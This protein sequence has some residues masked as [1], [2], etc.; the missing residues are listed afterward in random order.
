MMKKIVI[1]MLVLVVWTTSLF[2][3]ITRGQADTVILQHLQNIGL[4][5]SLLYVNVN[6]PS[7]S[8]IVITTSNAEVFSV[9]YACWAY[10]LKISEL[11]QCRYFFVKEDNGKLL[12]VIS[13]DDSGLK[14]LTQ[15]TFVTN[16]ILPKTITEGKIWHIESGGAC[17]QADGTGCACY[18]GL[19]TIKVGDTA[20]FNRKL[21][22]ELLSDNI[23]SQWEVVTY[24]REERGKVFFYTPN[25]DKEYL[26]YDFN[27]NVGD[28]VFL[29]DPLHPES[30][31]NQD[32]P[33]ELTEEDMDV[34]KFT[35]I[36]VDSIE[37]NQVKRK[38]LRLEYVSPY[39][40]DIWVE[41][42]GCMR[43]ITYHLA[44]QI[45]GVHQLKDCYES[46]TLIFV[47][48][49]PE[50]CWIFTS[51]INNIGQ[52]S[53]SIFIDGNNILHID[54]AKDIPLTIYDMKG[55]QI[56]SVS[57]TNNNYEINLSFLSK[58]LYV[59]SNPIKNIHFKIVIK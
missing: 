46:D 19:Q 21:Y 24:V 13:R 41:G 9:E 22:Y 14:D 18:F 50:Y 3:Q 27:L 5:D 44:Q 48:E 33:C 42:I 51:V 10:Y 1:I 57:P 20:T 58:G 28:T 26:M 31:V 30:F 59:I 23:N 56:Q 40:S 39:F 53:I 17:S 11:S 4:Q 2:S 55:R 52:N 32:N 45:S 54:N 12:E 47:N 8:G 35:V 38:M 15:W 49:N 43:G 34:C 37:Y 7:G 36:E 25:C 6:A 16:N 29:V